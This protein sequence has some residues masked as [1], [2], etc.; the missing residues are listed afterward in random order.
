MESL[1]LSLFLWLLLIAGVSLDRNPKPTNCSER[2]TQGKTHHEE[3]QRG[4]S[5]YRSKPPFVPVPKNTFQ[6]AI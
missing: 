3:L 2:Q 5:R 1:S 6:P 4:R